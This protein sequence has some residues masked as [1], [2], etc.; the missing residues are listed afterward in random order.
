MDEHNIEINE[1][2]E[3]WRNNLPDIVDYAEL[4]GAEQVHYGFKYVYEDPCGYFIE[5]TIRALVELKELK[6][7][8]N[9]AIKQQEENNNRIKEMII[10]TEK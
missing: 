4:V 9:D 1:L 5:E 7:I 10:M 3:Y 8:V 2:I 6:E